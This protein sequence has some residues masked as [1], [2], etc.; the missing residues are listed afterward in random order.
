[1]LQFLKFGCLG[2]SSL[3]P[4]ITAAFYFLVTLGLPSRIR[5]NVV[6]QSSNFDGVHRPSDTPGWAV[7]KVLFYRR[8]S[9]FSGDLTAKRGVTERMP[10]ATL[11]RPKTE[12]VSANE[13]QQAQALAFVR[14]CVHTL[15]GRPQ[16][17]IWLTAVVALTLQ[18][19]DPIDTQKQHHRH[20]L[21]AA[22][23]KH[24]AS[25]F[26]LLYKSRR[27]PKAEEHNK[28][29]TDFVPFAATAA[30]STRSGVRLVVG[31][32]SCQRA[33]K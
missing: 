28:P 6:Q 3:H 30:A 2:S 7:F 27:V 20:L 14:L 32:W 21:R 8:A 1:M 12:N 13:S 33:Q 18:L 22:E 29:C 9:G 25:L 5:S 24:D 10:V 26:G 17:N 11:S 15:G 4:P 23:G 31:G 16:A 19:V